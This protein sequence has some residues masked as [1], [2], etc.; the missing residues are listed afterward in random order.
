MARTS[1]LDALT[2][3]LSLDRADVLTVA[4]IV[5]GQLA[6]QHERGHHHGDVGPHTVLLDL[7]DPPASGV[8]DATLVAPRPEQ[9]PLNWPQPPEG[10]PGPAADAYCLGQVLRSLDARSRSAADDVG[11]PSF[12]RRLIDPNPDCRLTVR[13]LLEAFDEGQIRPAPKPPA[14]AAT[15]TGPAPAPESAAPEVAAPAPDAAAPAPGHPDPATE[16]N[17]DPPPASTWPPA[18]AAATVF[19][20]VL[21]GG[22]WWTGQDDDPTV[23]DTRPAQEA[24]VVDAAEPAADPTPTDTVPNEPTADAATPSE[25]GGAEAPSGEGSASGDRPSPG[26]TLGPDITTAP[27]GGPHPVVA[28]QA[29]AAGSTDFDQAWCRSHGVFVARV[30]TANYHATICRDGDTVNYH[31]LNLIDGLSIRTSATEHGAGWTGHG[32]EGITYEVSQELFE[33]R[34][35]DTVLASEDVATFIDP[36]QEGD[37]RPW[38]LHLTQPI[39]YPACQGAAI[40]V[41]DTF[42]NLQGV[43]QQVQESLD[44]HPGAGYLNTDA[45]CDSLGNPSHARGN[46][47]ITYY[48]AGHDEQEICDLVATA[49]THGLVLEDDAGPGEEFQCS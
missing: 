34:Q 35:G 13:E 8:R 44:A 7:A 4:E 49:G 20:L 19:L 42:A 18:V 30:Q 41:L 24:A 25:G 32:Q 23:P 33:V 29:E 38:D 10:R 11:L 22:L 14:P 5:A 27:D 36:T 45:A 6:G 43:N 28:E 31:G 21:A 47:F 15:L 1:I 26:A 37:F 9:R 48:W 40:V 17:P 46:E 39:S 3:G 12:I 2:A 16:P